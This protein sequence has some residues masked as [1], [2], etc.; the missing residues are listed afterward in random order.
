MG[1]RLLASTAIAKAGRLQRAP[2]RGA[3]RRPGGGRP[4][5]ANAVEWENVVPAVS[6]ADR[7]YLALQNRLYIADDTRQVIVFGV[8]ATP[9]ALEAV[10][11]SIRRRG[12]PIVE[13]NAVSQGKAH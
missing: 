9:L 11:A 4:R 12:L 7:F 1:I 8:T 2:R 13:A 6:L 3:R 5:T 10:N